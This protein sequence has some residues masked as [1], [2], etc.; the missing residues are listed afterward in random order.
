MIPDTQYCVFP[1]GCWRISDLIEISR[2]Y[3]RV[4]LPLELLRRSYKTTTAEERKGSAS[5]VQRALRSDLRYPVLVMQGRRGAYH[6][7]DGRHR[8]WKALH[9]GR[10]TIAARILPCEDLQSLRQEIW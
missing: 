2:Q 9:L 1:Q 3:P 5:F 7:L 10:P 6:L 8:F 4:R